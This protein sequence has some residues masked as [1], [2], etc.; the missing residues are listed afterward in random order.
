M[1]KLLPAARQNC[2]L[3]IDTSTHSAVTEYSK[4]R[5]KPAEGK[6]YASKVA[7]G[8]DRDGL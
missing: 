2:G 5:L 3:A 1:E 8:V 6:V 4:V 7:V